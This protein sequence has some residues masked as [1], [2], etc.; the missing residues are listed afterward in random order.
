[1]NERTTS[2]VKMIVVW[3]VSLLPLT[4]FSQDIIWKEDGE[5]LEVFI[6]KMR[7]EKIV[8][9]FEEDRKAKKFRIRYRDVSKVE[10]MDGMHYFYLQGR[11]ISMEPTDNFMLGWTDADFYYKVKPMAQLVTFI[12]SGA[13]AYGAFAVSGYFVAGFSY[14]DIFIGSSPPK[15]HNLNYPNAGLMENGEYAAGYQ[16]NALRIKERRVFKM[17][18]LG[19]VA[20]SLIALAILL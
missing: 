20:G 8:Y 13:L 2:Y 11:E 19:I 17:G 3:V 1:M 9:R 6:K 10:Q 15:E 16:E 7:F 12:S 14:T 18:A 5:V 4:S